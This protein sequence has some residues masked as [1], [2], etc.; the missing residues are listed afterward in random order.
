MA[1]R[2]WKLPSFRNVGGKNC[3]NENERGVDLLAP[4]VANTQL[5]AGITV[6]RGELFLSRQ[7]I[8]PWLILLHGN[9]AVNFLRV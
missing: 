2:L 6:I 1:E 9:T 7:W 8:V 3:S 4:L 5:E